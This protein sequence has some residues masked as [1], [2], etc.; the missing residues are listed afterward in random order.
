MFGEALIVTGA[1][2]CVFCSL[3]E[4]KES[5]GYVLFHI[6]LFLVAC[7]PSMKSRWTV[8]I[9]KWFNFRPFAEDGMEIGC[10]LVPMVLTSQIAFTERWADKNLTVT[11]VDRSYLLA[12]QLMSMVTISILLFLNNEKPLVSSFFFFLVTTSAGA[13]INVHLDVD[14]VLVSISVCLFFVAMFTILRCM[15]KSFTIGEAMI[16]T[17]AIVLLS[18]DSFTDLGVKLSHAWPAFRNIIGIHEEFT[19]STHTHWIQVLITGSLTTGVLLLPVFYYLTLARDYWETVAGYV[20]FYAAICFT[21]F[22]FLLPWSVLILGGTDPFT[23]LWTYLTKTDERLPL[24]AYWFCVVTVAVG[25]VAWKSKHPRTNASSTIVRK[26]FHLLA[27]AIYIPG[28]IYE[29]YLTHLASSVAVA[30]FIFIEYIRLY[31]IGPCGASIHAALKV[32]L[33]EKDSG[34]LILTHMYLLLGLAVPLWLYP[35]DYSKPDS[36]GCKLALYSG[37]LALGVG[38]TM[39][40]V[41]GKSLGRY[42]WPGSIKTVEGTLAG[43]MSQLLFVWTIQYAGVLL[44]PRDRWLTVSAAVTAGSLL[45]AWTSQIDNIILSPFLCSLLLYKCR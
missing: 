43:I 23:W 44:L 18:V 7:L 40:S 38:D 21:F 45:E 4:L 35:V 2:L 36:T 31:R 32:F 27:L 16:I 10:L 19:K 41:V 34:P 39:A 14:I 5:A 8:G 6:V 26:C 25:F 42:R 30:A 29:P 3:Y 33:D 9:K 17:E 20:A 11:V 22:A 28:V 1:S 24:I 37:I 15:P 12:S 13:T